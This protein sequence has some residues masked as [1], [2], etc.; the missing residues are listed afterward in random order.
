M[1]PSVCQLQVVENHQMDLPVI[2]QVTED[3]W[4]QAQVNEWCDKWK[5]GKWRV[6]EWCG[7]CPVLN[8]LLVT[9]LG[10]WTECE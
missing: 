9:R 5:G 4:K 10:C 6:N 2:L 8:S 7:K 3:G 1:P